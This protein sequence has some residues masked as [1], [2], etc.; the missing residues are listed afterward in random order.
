M[1][2]FF[3]Y[4]FGKGEEIEFRNFS[5]A[6]VLPILLTI[7]VVWLIW[8]YRDNLKEYKNEKTFVSFWLLP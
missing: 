4:F 8:H 1:K 6:H 5:L 3:H 2:E 7:A